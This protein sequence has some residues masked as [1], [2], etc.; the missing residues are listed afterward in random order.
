MSDH[1]IARQRVIA[2]AAAPLVR[3]ATSVRA[4]L[5]AGMAAFTLGFAV[6]SVLR[7]DAFNTGRFD[8][9]G[10]LTSTPC[11]RASRTICAGA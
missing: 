10:A 2:L 3:V 9:A 11:S 7:H 5:W 1:V 4:L 6:L 8:L